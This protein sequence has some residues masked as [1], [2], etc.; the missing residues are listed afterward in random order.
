MSRTDQAMKQDEPGLAAPRLKD[1]RVPSSLRTWFVIHFVA[2]MLFAIPLLLIPD[3]FLRWLGWQQID[4][5]TAR[6]AAA[7]LFGVGIESLLGRNAGLESFHT[8]LNLKIIWSL[9]CVIGIALSLFQGAQ[10]RP[11]MGWAILGVF[12]AFNALWTGWRLKLPSSSPAK[13]PGQTA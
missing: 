7:A 6:I 11:L 9:S 5:F 3:M 2:D 10:G 13:S 12:V 4:P 8:M 1:P